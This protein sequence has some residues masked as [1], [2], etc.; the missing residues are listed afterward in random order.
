MP[1]D[2]DNLELQYTSQ[3]MAERLYGAMVWQLQA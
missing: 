2:G 1:E 3:S